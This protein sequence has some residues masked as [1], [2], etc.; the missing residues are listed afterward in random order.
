[1]ERNILP[2][3]RREK[4]MDLTWLKCKKRLKSML[5]RN[6]IHGIPISF[7]AQSSTDHL[8]V[9]LGELDFLFCFSSI[10]VMV[11]RWNRPRSFRLHRSIEEKKTDSKLMTGAQFTKRL[12]KHE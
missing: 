5:Y 4:Q 3:E 6:E 2:A 7:S 8:E 10:V 9:F 12:K 1:M 11:Q